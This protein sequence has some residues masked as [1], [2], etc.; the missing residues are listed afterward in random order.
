MSCI[1]GQDQPGCQVF[2]TFINTST[3]TKNAAF[4]EVDHKVITRRVF[5]QFLQALFKRK[6]QCFKIQNHFQALVE[7]EKLELQNE[8]LLKQWEEALEY[9]TTVSRSDFID[10]PWLTDQ[11]SVDCSITFGFIIKDFS[12]FLNLIYKLYFRDKNC[13]AANRTRF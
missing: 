8:Q 11:A 10:E 4:V 13:I 1:N 3:N 9:V 12:A 6:C 7:R 5:I 2:Y